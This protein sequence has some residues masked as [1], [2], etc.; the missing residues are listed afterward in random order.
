[1]TIDW[2]LLSPLTNLLSSTK[3]SKLNNMVTN[4]FQDTH[5]ISFDYKLTGHGQ[6]SVYVIKEYFVYN[7]PVWSTQSITPEW[8]TV[9]L[10]LTPQA[11]KVRF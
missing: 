4:L 8:T 9:Q 6:L 1:M 5:C 2:I 10:A 11:Y 3:Y 7:H